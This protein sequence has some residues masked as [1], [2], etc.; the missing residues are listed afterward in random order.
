MM[1][2][3]RLR[4]PV[5]PAYLMSLGQ[6][7]YCFASLE[8]NAVYCGEKL[9]PG[10]VYTIAKKTAGKIANDLAGFA[11][12]IADNNKRSRYQAAVR[13]F[14][15]LVDRRNDLVHANPATIG[16]D[17]RLVRKGTPWQP[18]DIDDLADEFTVCSI[19]LNE[20]FHHIL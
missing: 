14:D 19:E 6:A 11:D 8:W 20:L 1:K 9:S 15:R 3:D 12:L 2:D 5:D 18:N 7:I 13:E 10:Y 17:Q 16:C 4:V